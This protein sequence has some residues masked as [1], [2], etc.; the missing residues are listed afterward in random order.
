MSLLKIHE[1][2]IS[3]KREIQALNEQGYLRNR[4]QVKGLEEELVKLILE[5][6]DYLRSEN[7]LQEAIAL[8]E[9]TPRSNTNV[10]PKRI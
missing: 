4:T 9:I 2:I 10:K 6:Q 7:A 3:K 8:S 5:R 1:S